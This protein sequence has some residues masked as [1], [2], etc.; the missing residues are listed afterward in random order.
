MNWEA[1]GAISELIGAI[2]VVVTLAYLAVQI[3]QNSKALYSSTRFEIAK[4]QM[5]IN[6]LLAQHPDLA[7][8]AYAILQGKEGMSEK[9]QLAASQYITGMF[10][11]FENQFYA[12]REGTFSESVWGGYR[13][14]IAWNA[15]QPKFPEFWKERRPLFSEDFAVLV[16]SLTISKDGDF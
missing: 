15:G 4:T 9:D 10:R 8:G 16:D 14:N 2:A 12:Y 11:T 5:D 3:R 6:F 1:T 7:V 13:R